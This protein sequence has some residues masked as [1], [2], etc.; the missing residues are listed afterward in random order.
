MQ[1]KILICILL[2][3][4]TGRAALVFDFEFGA[5]SQYW[6]NEAINALNTAA[7]TLASYLQV[8]TPVTLRYHVTGYSLF[9]GTLASAGSAISA[10]PGFHKTI[11]QQKILTG[12]DANGSAPDGTIDWNFGHSWGFGESIPEG[13]YDF[14]SV[15]MH[16]LLHTFGFLSFVNSAGNNTTTYWSEF[17]SFIVDS[18]GNAPI[19]TH[20]YLWDSSFDSNLTGGND[21]L[22]FGGPNTFATFGGLVPLYTP[23][24]WLS[25]SSVAHLDTTTFTGQNS[26]LMS[27]ST[28]SGTGI[29]TLSN[30]ELAILE[31]L[32][33]AINYSFLLGSDTSQAPTAIPEPS[34]WLMA[35]LALCIVG[36]TLGRRPIAAKVLIL[37]EK[38]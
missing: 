32:G 9:N 21:G 18:N 10:S 4:L 38:S 5:G 8:T 7:N 36:G 26:K 27:H 14:Q 37:R 1:I 19:S 31:D 25:G 16:E 22:Y 2:L 28:S 13:S 29:R 23:D 30:V 33:Y 15:A 24:P 34:T 11:V 17:D 6:S 3:P 12:L 35:L 20:T